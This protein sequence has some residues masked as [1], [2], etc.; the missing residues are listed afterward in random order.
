MK[1]FSREP[2][3]RYVNRWVGV[4]VL[5]TLLIFMLAVLG[6]G[7]VQKWFNP[8]AR[9]KIILPEDGLFGLSEGADVEIL[10]TKAGKVVTIV[11]DPEQKM[12]AAVDINPDMTVFVRQD[13]RAVIRKQFGV[14]GAAYLE[15]SRGFGEP[16][17]W[18]YAV[19]DATADRAPTE[20]VGALI[21][22]VRKKLFPVLEDTHEA[23]R[24]LKAVAQDLQNPE[25]NL[26]TLLAGLNTITTRIAGGEGA[27]GRLLARED[28]AD[29]LESMVATVN[30]LL[31]IGR[32]HV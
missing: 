10:G 11:I 25:G 12:Y 29:D 30:Q 21:E 5:G 2:E 15:I 27:V 31:Q 3:F 6:S 1:T 20:T 28:L 26:Q 17:D 16:L 8:G 13:S 18:D 32:A 19:L 14:A 4:F 24:T 7:R 23:I 9:I 22:E